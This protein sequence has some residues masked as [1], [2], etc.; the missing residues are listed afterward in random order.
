MKNIKK[1]IITG[2]VLGGL[3]IGIYSVYSSPF[4]GAQEKTKMEKKL[5]DIDDSQND[6]VAK[7]KKCKQVKKYE[8]DGFEYETHEYVMP[9][10]STGYQTFIYKEVDGKR[11][12]KSVGEGKESKERSKDWSLIVDGE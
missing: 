8:E 10:G 7:G 11:Y 5:K 4:F 2:L 9:D 6:C 3:S 12:V 1:T